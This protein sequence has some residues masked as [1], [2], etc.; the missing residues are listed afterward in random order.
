MTLVVARVRDGAL[1]VATTGVFL[2]SLV[3]MVQLLPEKKEKE[4]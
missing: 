1:P 3:L 4:S 2:Y